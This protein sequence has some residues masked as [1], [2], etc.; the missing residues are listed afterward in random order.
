MDDQYV[1]SFRCYLSVL[2]T[3]GE[4]V[5]ELPADAT[6]NQ[7]PALLLTCWQHLP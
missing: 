7:K 6:V 4:A 3:V 5:S 2:V 1:P